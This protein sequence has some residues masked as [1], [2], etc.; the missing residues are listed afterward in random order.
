MILEVIGN[1]NCYKKITCQVGWGDFKPQDKVVSLLHVVAP[2]RHYRRFKRV[3]TKALTKL[4][5][6]LPLDPKSALTTEACIN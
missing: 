4:P 3:R 1:L 5:Y 2:L 6:I